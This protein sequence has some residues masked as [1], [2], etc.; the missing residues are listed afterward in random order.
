MILLTVIRKYQSEFI[1]CIDLR[2]DLPKTIVVFG[3]E[4]TDCLESI[5]IEVV[6][7]SSSM[8]K[9][10]LT[11]LQNWES[12]CAGVSSLIKFQVGGL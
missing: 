7:Q 5:Y 1:F 12:T 6:A 3:R 2:L 4:N 11:F 8:K 9:M 10:F